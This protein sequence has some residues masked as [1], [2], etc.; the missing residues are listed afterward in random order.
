M[1]RIQKVT[2][3]KGHTS[4]ET[5]YVVDGYPYGRLRTQKRYWVE[6]AAKGAKK[7]QQRV[8]GQTLNPKGGYW[9]KPKAGTY[10]LQAFLFLNPD[11]DHVEWYY[12]S[13]YG[14]D[15]RRDIEFRLMGL[16]DQLDADDRDIYDGIL[17]LSRTSSYRIEKAED[18]RR[19]R[20]SLAEQLWTT[21]ELPAYDASKR[22]VPG[23]YGG[24]V[25]PEVYKVAAAWALAQEPPAG[26]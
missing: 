3:L 17:Q 6:T 19:L 8:M 1:D 23:A 7:G 16:Y 18:F 5:A 25:D 11:N 20:E 13:T 14:I 21:G 24:Y 22:T 2:L 26:G 12:V 9:N 15:P 4:P 10:Y